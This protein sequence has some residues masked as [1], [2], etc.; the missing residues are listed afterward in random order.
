MTSVKQFVGVLGVV[1]CAA[2]PTLAQPTSLEQIPYQ[3][4]LEAS[5]KAQDGSFD[6]R[7]EIVNAQG[8]VQWFD[9]FSSVQVQRGAFGVKLG[10]GVAFPAGL[11]QQEELYL[12]IQVKPTG[13]GVFTS[14]QGRQQLLAVPYAQRSTE[15]RDFQVTGALH[16][17]SGATVV[18]DITA[19]G[20]LSAAS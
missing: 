19:T 13:P 18:G 8:T 7:F 9:T 2:S 12:Q 17:G 15:A 1:V 20:Q 10:S 3:G 5:G 14:L 6:F 11:W 4:H 16:V